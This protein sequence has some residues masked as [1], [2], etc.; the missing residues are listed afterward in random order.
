[1]YCGGR[2]IFWKQVR[3]ALELLDSHDMLEF[4]DIFSSEALRHITFTA[5]FRTM[6]RFQPKFGWKRSGVPLFRLPAENRS[7]GA[8]DAKDKVYAFTG[9]ATDTP[10]CLKDPDYKEYPNELYMRTARVIVETT[11]VLDV[12]SYASSTEKNLDLPS[13]A[14]NW[15]IIPRLRPLKVRTAQ[16]LNARDYEKN[17]YRASRN[18]K[19]TLKSLSNP[20]VL[21]LSGFTVDENHTC[22]LRNDRA[23][24][25][26]SRTTNSKKLCTPTGRNDRSH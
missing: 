8:M 13:W 14:P 21:S 3:C 7:R 11:R 6:G 5:R 2:S 25:Q 24:E 20:L 17:L 15:T 19:S 22:R 9:L 1:M 10:N 16:P 4:S 26:S 18:S 12:L 23:R